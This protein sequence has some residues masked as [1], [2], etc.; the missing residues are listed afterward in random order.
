MLSIN[1]VI[2]SNFC[3]H[4]FLE[5]NMQSGLTGI[6]G[7]N[8]HGKSNMANAVCA[9]LTGSFN[10][11]PEGAAGCIRQNQEKEL[12]TFVEISGTLASQEFRLRR[13][14]T[15]AKISH[16]LWLDGE[17][18]SDRAKDIEQWI[19]D[20]SGLTPQMMSEFMFIGQQD[21]YSFLE[22]NDADRSKK[23]AALC[24]TRIYERLRDE[25]SEMLRSDK[26]KYSAANEASIETLKQSLALSEQRK[27]EVLGVIQKYDEHLQTFESAEKIRSA[28]DELSD[29]KRQILEF[30]KHVNGLDESQK[31][32]DEQAAAVKK[33]DDRHAEVLADLSEVIKQ[34]QCVEEKYGE[35]LPEVC[36]Q[37]QDDL[38]KTKEY[39]GLCKR[40]SQQMK[41]LL[42]VS[43]KAVK[44]DGEDKRD[45][46]SAVL[47]QAE[48]KRAE[49]IAELDS[50]SKV[51]SVLEQL[52]A[53]SAQCPLCGAS[54]EHWTVEL[55][56]SAAKK[57]ELL[58][59]LEDVNTHIVEQ[60][61]N[62]EEIDRTIRR[63]EMLSAR[64]QEAQEN[65]DA[66]K[67]ELTQY[68]EMPDYL[69]RKYTDGAMEEIIGFI[70]ERLEAYRNL[71]SRRDALERDSRYHGKIVL[72]YRSTLDAREINVQRI[73]NVIARYKEG[74]RTDK[75][76]KTVELNRQHCINLLQER[77]AVEDKRNVCRGQ[78]TEI[79]DSIAGTKKHLE[80]KK[81]MLA[82]FGK[83]D[84]FFAYFDKA[85]DW[86]KK[87]GLP[88]LIHR[89]I[90]RQLTDVINS[91]LKSFSDPFSAEVN[92][93][94]TFTALFE[95]GRQINSKALSG[96]QKVMLALSFWSAIN[97]TF[98]KNLGIM[99]LDEPT[100]GLD[101]D[102]MER[103]YGV[104]DRWK[105]LLHQRGQQVVIITHD[106]GMEQVFDTVF[107][108]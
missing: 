91:E 96:G 106:E 62:L 92:D 2:L 12:D 95:D 27:N 22:A 100:D 64:Q 37:I 86:L 84:K 10:R 107:H 61:E 39:D 68:K 58:S 30:Q 23:F 87:D 63:Y 105:R 98:A 15:P 73:K 97:R 101:T 19:T 89:S 55:K 8:G 108:L 14:I 70:S 3:Q 20:A 90:L 93:D 45:S 13:K 83:T 79:E 71:V 41:R 67:Q 49:L 24:N 56:E 46:I 5:F 72:Q 9:A 38:Q 88:R 60:Q 99:I 50:L 54:A 34:I 81:Q 66:L 94:L 16:T 59:S 25:Y 102:N 103:L 104:L 48:K 1:K 53:V 78:L 18:F 31:S 69:A 11:H 77:T 26:A 85:V 75:D 65:L 36:A 21:L 52:G 82:E 28:I 17:K 43:K 57:A 80:Q 47:Q 51:L 4:E 7:K 44:P 42:E 33:A 74:G 40:V 32:L 6:A 76:L 35:A 29:I